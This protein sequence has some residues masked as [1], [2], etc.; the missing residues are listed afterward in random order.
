M[1]KYYTIQLTA[2]STSPGPYTIYWNSPNSEP[3]IPTIYPTTQ[4][5]Q[6]LGLTSLQNGVTI[7][8]PDITNIIYVYNQTALCTFITLTPPAPPITVKVA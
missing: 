2:E 8:V 5:A 3:N 1:N 6:N 4:L 7:S